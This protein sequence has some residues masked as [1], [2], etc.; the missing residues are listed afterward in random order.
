LGIVKDIHK[1]DMLISL[2]GRTSGVLPMTSISSAY[3]GAMEKLASNESVDGVS[4]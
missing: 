3:T 4:S 1:H 2:P